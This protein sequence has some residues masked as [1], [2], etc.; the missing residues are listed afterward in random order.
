MYFEIAKVRRAFQDRLKCQ[1]PASGVRSMICKT[2]YDLIRFNLGDDEGVLLRNLSMDVA[3]ELSGSQV[4]VPQAEIFKDLFSLYRSRC[5]SYR[6]SGGG[7]YNPLITGFNSPVDDWDDHFVISQ[8]RQLASGG[9][10]LFPQKLSKLF[11]ESE[12]KTGHIKRL[13]DRSDIRYESQ[14][15]V[16]YVDLSCIAVSELLPMIDLP[17]LWVRLRT[18]VY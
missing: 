7:P 3:D 18:G 2:A 14:S 11:Y 8:S 13:F 16:G 5:F 12:E 17:Y 6:D 15:V 1:L 4:N 9:L 10:P